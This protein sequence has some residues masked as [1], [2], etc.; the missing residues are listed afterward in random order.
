MHLSCSRKPKGS[1]PGYVLGLFQENLCF[2]FAR[3]GKIL[4]ETEYPDARLNDRLSW[5]LLEADGLFVQTELFLQQIAIF[6]YEA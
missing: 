2:K 6:W 3:S 1:D 5:V 4:Q